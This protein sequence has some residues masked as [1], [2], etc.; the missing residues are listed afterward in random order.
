MNISRFQQTDRDDVLR[1]R[2][3][4]FGRMNLAR[5]LWQP[6]QQAESLEKDC[7]KLVC[8]NEKVKG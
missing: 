7:G 5:F 6:C 4:T 8:T 1:L 2:D 3:E